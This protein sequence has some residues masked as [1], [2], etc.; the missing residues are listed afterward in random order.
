MA[1]KEKDG[2]GVAA[3]D[4]GAL[5]EER[6]RNRGEGQ[7]SGEIDTGVEDDNL[8]ETAMTAR[9]KFIYRS[10]SWQW[11]KIKIYHVDNMIEKRL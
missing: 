7:G 2:P 4:N 9:W 10:P 1:S 3:D 5:V 11:D 6:C 8:L